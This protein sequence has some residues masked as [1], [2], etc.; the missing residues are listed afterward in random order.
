M[1]IWPGW[2]HDKDEDFDLSEERCGEHCRRLVW[3][4]H[5]RCCH[6]KRP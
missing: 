2:E 6:R 1:N 5:C 3:G 4:L